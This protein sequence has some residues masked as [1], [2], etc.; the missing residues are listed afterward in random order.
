MPAATTAF[1]FITD[2]LADYA[3]ESGNSALQSVFQWAGNASSTFATYLEENPVE[4]ATA[5]TVGMFA[6]AALGPEAVTATAIDAL[7]LN[8]ETYGANLGITSSVANSIATA[9]INAL[10][11]Q[12]GET[13][14]KATDSM[15]DTIVSSLG[16]SLTSVAV[17][18]SNIIPSNTSS[19]ANLVVAASPDS[20]GNTDELLITLPVPTQDTNT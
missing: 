14:V 11:E 20:S 8:L 12:T 10:I 3:G 19:T 4:A 2:A 6:V 15:I 17:P 18:N 1:G 13:A 5:M 9:A 7:A 16:G